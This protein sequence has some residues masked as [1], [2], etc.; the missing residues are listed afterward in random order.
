[1]PAEIP[2]ELV[3]VT[4]TVTHNGRPIA[5]A[6]AAFH[7]AKSS[8][9]VE[10]AHAMTDAR[11]RYSLAMPEHGTGAMPGDY[12]VTVTHLNGGIPV[13]YKSEDFS[14]WHVEPEQSQTIWAGTAES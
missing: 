14:P 11:G 9:D 12:V 6:S 1:M 4:G 13:Q 8:A 3:A 7:P 5:R 2:P 10:F